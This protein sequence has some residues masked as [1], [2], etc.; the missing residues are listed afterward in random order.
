MKKLM[1]AIGFTVLGTAVYSQTESKVTIQTVTSTDNDLFKSI[2]PA[3]GAPAVF[4]NQAE[5][6]AKRADK[7]DKVKQRLMENKE[8]PEMVK[9]LKEDLWRFENAI[10][11]EIKN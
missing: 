5:L 7:I 9:F 3:D 11:K 6:D 1:M 4:A 10:A 8:N 2:K